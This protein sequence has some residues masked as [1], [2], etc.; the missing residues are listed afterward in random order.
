LKVSE[1]EDGAFTVTV[2]VDSYESAK[3]VAAYAALR[4]NQRSAKNRQLPGQI[5]M[6]DASSAVESGTD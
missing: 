2:I 1:S 4:I 6:F 3:E 5:G